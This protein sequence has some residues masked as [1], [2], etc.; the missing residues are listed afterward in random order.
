MS[1]RYCEHEFQFQQ[2][3]GENKKFIVFGRDH[4]FTNY[5]KCLAYSDLSNFLAIE[6]EI[7]AECEHL[8]S[9]SVYVPLLG[10]LCM[11]KSNEIG[12]VRCSYL[13]GTDE[14]ANVYLWDYGITLDVKKMDI[15]V[16]MTKKIF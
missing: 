5:W 10:E 8:Q 3:N 14:M 6:S 2:L 12:W 16:C 4:R 7:Q 9:G 15:R 11:I 13:G 1:H